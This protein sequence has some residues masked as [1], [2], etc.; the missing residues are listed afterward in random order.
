MRLIEFTTQHPVPDSTNEDIGSM[1]DWQTVVAIAAAAKMTPLAIKALWKTAKG[2]YKVK[3]LADRA[4]IK[5]ANKA[6]K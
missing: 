5:L 4:G 6:I 3:K 2:A 1:P